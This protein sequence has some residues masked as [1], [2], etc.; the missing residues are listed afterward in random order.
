M[1]LIS[2]FA[3]LVFLFFVRDASSGVP[4]TLQLSRMLT[5]VRLSILTSL[6]S[7]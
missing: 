1:H 3:A 6:G 5:Y 7:A 4:P 2:T